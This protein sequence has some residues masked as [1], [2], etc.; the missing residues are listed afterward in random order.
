MIEVFVIAA[1]SMLALYSLAEQKFVLQAV[2][3]SIMYLF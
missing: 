2:V 3:I 1:F